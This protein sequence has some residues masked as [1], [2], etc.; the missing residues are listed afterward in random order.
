MSDLLIM[1]LSVVVLALAFLGVVLPWRKFAERWVG[2]DPTRATVYV[3]D[4]EDLHARPGQLVYQADEGTFFRYTWNGGRAEVLAGPEYPVRYLRGRRL[5]AV[6]AGSIR[7]TDLPMTG[8][9]DQAFM[10]VGAVVQGRVMVQLVK[11]IAGP[12]K[13]PWLWLLIGAGVL[14]AGY[15]IGMQLFPEQMAALMPGQGTA[16]QAAGVTEV[17][18]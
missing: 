5:V 6:T 17:V 13:S 10:D 16:S 8:E 14:I 7:A 18:P 4:G 12:Q 1:G 15:F 11:E 9:T 2:N 3:R